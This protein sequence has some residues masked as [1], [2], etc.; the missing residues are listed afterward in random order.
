MKRNFGK[1]D[2]G[3]GGRSVAA[4]AAALLLTSLVG[5]NAL[6]APRGGSAGFAGGHAGHE[7]AAP[8]LNSVPSNQAPTFNP[9]TPYT[10]PTTPE[11]PVS[12]A[13]PG[14]VF[15]NG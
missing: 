6:A 10:M 14:S 7:R 9:S 15:G 11:A 3:N 1:S 4:V 13:S 12:P 8:F 2:F 5:T